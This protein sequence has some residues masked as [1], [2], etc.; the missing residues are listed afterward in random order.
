VTWR[1]GRQSVV[2]IAQPNCL[3]EIEETGAVVPESK[4]AEQP[5]KPIFEDVSKRLS[6]SHHEDPFDDFARQPLL[7][8]RLS[9]LGPGVC[10]WDVDGDGWEDLVIGSGKGAELACYRNEHQGEFK[11]FSQAPWRTTAL[12]DQTAIVGWATGSVLVGTANYEDGAATGGAVALYQSGQSQPLDLIAADDSSVGPLA[13]AD[14]DGDGALDLFVGGRVKA[15]KYP[16]PASSRLYHRQGGKLLLDERN[17]TQLR[18]VGLVSGAVWSDLAG[19]GYPE[20]ILACEWGP[21]RIFHNDHGLLKLWDISVESSAAS[22]QSQNPNSPLTAQTMSLSGL[23]GWWNG[24]TTGDIDGDGKPDIIALNWGLNTKYRASP[25]SPQRIY[26]GDFND[27]GVMDIIEC[28]RDEVSGKEVPERDFDSLSLGVGFVRGRFASYAEYDQASVAEIL[29][30]GLKAARSLQASTLQSMLFL[31]RS[32][33][34]IAI[35]LPR[36]AQFSTA[37][38]ACVGDYDG[39]GF[40]DVF[41][42]QNF[43]ATE[44]KTPRC[45]AGRGLWLRGDGRGGLQAVSGQSSGVMVYGEQRGAALCD[46]D[47]DGR[48]DL[49]VTQNGAE[50]KLFHNV[51]A[52][53]GVRVRLAGPAGNSAGIGA[54]IRLDYGEHLGPAREV[55]GGSGYWSQDGVVQ[56]LGSQE[57]PSKVWVRWP[58]GKITTTPLSPGAQ[59]IVITSPSP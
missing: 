10:W 8:K 1:S 53:P 33:R 32:N 52:K 35:P 38:A 4:T 16:V 11:K 49:V 27:D 19:D 28:T 23:T 17:T 50:T 21:I 18:D 56:V 44:S 37:F 2:P 45:D 59:E 14:Y 7:P 41:I 47:H 46:Y 58:G 29:D 5:E 12:R 24:V 3:Y 9:Q 13:V 20:L 42:S 55:H 34:F 15:G 57:T 30:D 6:H 36:E 25:A 51:G 31:N 43:F 39:D 48:V 22:G 40:E 26:Y 54:A